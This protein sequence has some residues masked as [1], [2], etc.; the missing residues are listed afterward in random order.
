M[1]K[2]LISYHKLPAALDRDDVDNFT[3]KIASND[4]ATHSESLWLA[5][6]PTSVTDGRSYTVSVTQSLGANV[7]WFGKEGTGG[8]E[9]SYSMTKSETVN[10]APVQIFN[11]S[12]NDMLHINFLPSS[13]KSANFQPV[14]AGLLRI[15]DDGKGT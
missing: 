13:D 9:A 3:Y 7:G 14:V 12:S 2:T 1:L 6:S 5:T 8:I 4:I 15:P 10:V 11:R